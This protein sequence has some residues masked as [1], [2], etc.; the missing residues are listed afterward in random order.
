MNNK[1]KLYKNPNRQHNENHKQY[2]PQYQ[3]L[4]IEPQEINGFSNAPHKPVVLNS[5]IEDETSN[6]NPRVRNIG[7]RQP[8]AEPGEIP[9]KLNAGQV[10]NVGNNMEHAWTEFGEEKIID[11]LDHPMIDNNDYVTEAALGF[12][13]EKVLNQPSNISPNIFNNIADVKNNQYLLLLDNVLL[14]SGSEEDVSK[15]LELLVF[16][17]HP[18]YNGELIN[19]ERLVVLK[20]I[21][22]KVGVLLG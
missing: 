19:P 16:G 9:V 21:N 15:Q 14:A 22:I 8:Y 6:L 7:I 5:K 3:L 10:P 1:V 12:K 4:G 11:D 13:E 2:V 18:N 20:R 17:D